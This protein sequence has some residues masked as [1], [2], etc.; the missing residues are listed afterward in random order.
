MTDAANITV[1]IVD[2]EPDI[3]YYLQTILEDAGFEVMTA[4]NGNQALDCMMETKPDVISLDLVMPKMSGVKF[5]TYIQKNKD[6]KD[7]PVVVLTAHGKDEMGQKDLE[8]ILA[9]K[10]KGASV[11]FLEKPVDPPRYINAIRAALGLELVAD[12]TTEAL[13]LELMEKMRKAGRDSLQRAIKEL[14]D[15][16]R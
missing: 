7:I 10:E 11:S 16:Q 5:F 8:N 15:Q 1:L 2:D 12:D 14:D 3:R 13:K 9:H 6:R 4:A